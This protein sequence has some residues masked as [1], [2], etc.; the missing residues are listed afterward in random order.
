MGKTT[1]ISTTEEPN[2]TQNPT[3]IQSTTIT[4]ITFLPNGH[5]MPRYG[6]NGKCLSIAT[7]WWKLGFYDCDEKENES[8]FSYNKETLQIKSEYKEDYCWQAFR[9]S[10]RKYR[11]GLRSCD[12]TEKLQQFT[13][14][15]ASGFVQIKDVNLCLTLNPRYMEATP[16]F[17]PCVVNSFN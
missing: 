15:L 12:T 1:Q 14:D 10:D 17:T 7:K 4:Q 8:V 11:L 2:T 5:I 13:H 6:Y 16:N 9:K 3:T